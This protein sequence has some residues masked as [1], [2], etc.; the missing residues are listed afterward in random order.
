MKK[1]FF[2]VLIG[3]TTVVLISCN[4]NGP[5]QT[6]TV[7]ENTPPMNYGDEGRVYIDNEGK[8]ILR[9]LSEGEETLSLKDI[10]NDKIYDLN[11]VVSASGAKYEDENG[12][13]FWSKGDEAVFGQKESE[14]YSGLKRKTH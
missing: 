8:E 5:S 7:V 3:L 2:F 9:I 12:F 6:A 10:T 11:L 13:Y 14:I 4:R 1:T